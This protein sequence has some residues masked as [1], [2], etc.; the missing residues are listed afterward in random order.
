MQA[1]CSIK[2]INFKEKESLEG[3][4]CSVIRPGFYTYNLLE[5]SKIDSEGGV[6][7]F[8]S[9]GKTTLK[10]RWHDGQGIGDLDY[11][12]SYK[13]VDGKKMWIPF[14]M[15]TVTIEPA[16]NLPDF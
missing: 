9:A 5:P 12:Y 1:K 15:A 13:S 4:A 8:G 6:L 10:V 2:N 16:N 11:A 3:A 7:Q 14:G